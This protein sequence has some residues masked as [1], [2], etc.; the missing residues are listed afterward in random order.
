MQYVLMLLNNW[1][2]INFLWITNYY[3]IN[4]QVI[5]KFVKNKNIMIKN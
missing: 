2:K 4:N 5:N 1:I 3:E